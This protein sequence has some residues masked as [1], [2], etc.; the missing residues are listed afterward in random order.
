ML[1]ISAHVYGPNRLGVRFGGPFFLVSKGVTRL[2]G[3]DNP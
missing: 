1:V 2:S 3:D